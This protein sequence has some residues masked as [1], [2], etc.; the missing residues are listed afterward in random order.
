MER[1]VLLSHGL[2]Q[3][4]KECMMEKSDTYRWGVCRHCG[5][6]SKYTPRRDLI[7][8][9]NCGLQDISVIETP[10]AFKLLIQEMEAMGI[11]IRLSEESL[12]EEDPD[13]I[14]SELYEEIKTHP[15]EKK[16][17]GKKGKKAE[18]ESDEDSDAES[19]EESQ[20]ENE[21]GDESDS[22][23][24]SELDGGST[25]NIADATNAD[26]N[27]VL[28][29]SNVNDISVDDD[30][31]SIGGESE[32]SDAASSLKLDT[33]GLD[34]DTIYSNPPIIATG[35]ELSL[36]PMDQLQNFS[37]KTSQNEMAMNDQLNLT[38][39]NSIMN[40][41]KNMADLN[42]VGATSIAENMPP[43]SL[44]SAKMPGGSSSSDLR[45]ININMSSA[46]RLPEPRQKGNRGGGGGGDEYE[47]HGGD[48]DTEF[49][50]D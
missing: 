25:E 3:F 35:A 43:M 7:E 15:K 41:A 48:D 13:L 31:K 36:N 6:L 26:V 39:N 49:F 24:E 38:Q 30:N 28:S 29:I 37:K 18:S 27:R 14:Y 4:A 2:A 5:I 23:A 40:S 47:D 22:D 44:A 32:L 11:Q 12:P 16:T 34:D 45:V 50:T 33:D 21:S 8:C 42:N 19:A 1:D 20:S 46:S 9:L 10:Y 17:K